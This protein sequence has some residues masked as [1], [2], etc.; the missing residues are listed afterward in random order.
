[1][2]LN[3]ISSCVMIKLGKV[4]SNRMIDLSVTNT[5]LYDR[6]LRIITDLLKINREEA[7]QYL[8]MGDGSV[9]LS[10]LIGASGLNKI[11]SKQLLESSKGNLRVALAKIG[12]TLSID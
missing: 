7:K 6:S 10:L 12:K 9:K 3:M 2:A 11:K 5:K 1:M 8:L 4:Y